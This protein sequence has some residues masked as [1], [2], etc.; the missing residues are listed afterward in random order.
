MSKT[1][2]EYDKT[3]SCAITTAGRLGQ[4]LGMDMVKEKGLRCAYVI[5]KQPVGTLVTERAVPVAIFSASLEQR[6]E[7][8]QK[9]TK[10]KSTD[11]YEIRDVVDWDYYIT[12][13]SSAIQ[14]IITIPAAKQNVANPCPGVPHPD[15][16]VKQL[17]NK[18]GD[19]SK[20][21]S[22]VNGVIDIEDMANKDRVQVWNSK[23]GQKPCH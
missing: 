8:L 17:S 20:M 13:L 12:R 10:G 16:L 22:R 4:F 7:F 18:S 5:S 15:W 19:I 3:K 2:D 23:L 21:F 1:M 9:W 11:S 14:K 6:R